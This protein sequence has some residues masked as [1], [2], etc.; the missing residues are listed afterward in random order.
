MS[1]TYPLSAM[2]RIAHLYRSMPRTID[3]PSRP[4]GVRQ[5]RKRVT[6]KL[7]YTVSLSLFA[8]L[9]S[10][11]SPG[12]AQP[13]QPARQAQN[14]RQV[15]PPTSTRIDDAAATEQDNLRILAS[16]INAK[17]SQ[18]FARGDATSI[19]NMYTPTATY[20]E[21]MPRLSM[22]NGRGQIE[23]HFRE[24]FSAHVTELNSTVTSAQ[25][26]NADTQL[27]GG[28][29]SLVGNGKRTLGHFVQLLK[30]DGG[31]WRISSHIFAR[32]EPV[33][34]E[35]MNDFKGN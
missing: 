6:A 2:E 35:E 8:A 1:S 5:D 7:A 12:F 28:D 10:Y 24:L 34:F 25:M 16:N 9:I 13:S 32:P 30:R 19:A 15:Y 29:Y 11:T 14:S 27:V 4:Y 22:M 31:E 21:L 26:V 17:R 33:T 18:Y 3:P 23:N 20:I